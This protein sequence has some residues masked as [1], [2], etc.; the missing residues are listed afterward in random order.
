M[1]CDDVLLTLEEFVDGEL[2]PIYTEQTRLHLETC[3]SC[4]AEF[5]V[6]KDEQALFAKYDRGFDVPPT[7]WNAIQAQIN[8]ETLVE[9]KSTPFEQ[10]K[11]WLREIF[12]TPQL[13]P[14]FALILIVVTAGVTYWVMR[15]ASVQPVKENIAGNGTSNPPLPAPA[16]GNNESSPKPQSTGVPVKSSVA[17]AKSAAPVRRAQTPAELIRE[18]EQKYVSAILLLQRDVKR[19]RENLDPQV[20]ARLETALGTVDQTI[21][22]T[23]AVARK[24]PNDPVA[25][26]YMLAAY[27]K[28]VE[29]LREMTNAPVRPDQPEPKDET[30]P[31]S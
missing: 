17:V 21:A 3:K 22:E 1:N 24:N 23:R 19:Q 13:S 2:E 14:A 10:V 30:F 31:R 18:A 7:M 26:Q 6:L 16:L 28:K 15:P 12:K 11:L 25:V 20:I 29:I 5:E 4:W 9:Q 8:A 27:G